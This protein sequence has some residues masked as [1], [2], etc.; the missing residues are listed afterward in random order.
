MIGIALWSVRGLWAVGAAACL[1]AS[2]LPVGIDI[3][4]RTAHY[5]KLSSEVAALSPEEQVAALATLSPHDRAKLLAA[6]SPED[7]STAIDKLFDRAL[8]CQGEDREFAVTDLV[9][10]TESYALLSMEGLKII[11]FVT[12]DILK[13]E[14][15]SW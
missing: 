13:S 5:G 2:D 8:L 9:V 7:R 11:N 4:R 6:M 14:D 1:L 10:I 15:A 3:L 12:N